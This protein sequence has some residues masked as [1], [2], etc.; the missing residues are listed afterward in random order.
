MPVINN[1]ETDKVYEIQDARVDSLTNIV[2]KCIIIGDSYADGYSPDGSNTSWSTQL[3]NALSNKYNEIITTSLGGVGFIMNISLQKSFKTLLEEVDIDD[4]E[5]VT[6]IIVCGGWNDTGYTVDVL[7]EA[8]NTFMTYAKA[9]YPNALITVGMIGADMN[10]NVKILSLIDIVLKCYSNVGKYGN[11]RFIEN[12]ETILHSR[13]QL[14][15]DRYH[16]NQQGQNDLF[17]KILNFLKGGGVNN[18]WGYVPKYAVSNS[19]PSPYDCVG[20]IN[21]FSC[22][23]ATGFELFAFVFNTPVTIPQGQPFVI[24]D[25]EQ[26]NFIKAGYGEMTNKSVVVLIAYGDG[27]YK[28]E[29]VQVCVNDKYIAVINQSLNDEGTNFKA[30]ENVKTIDFLGAAFYYPQQYI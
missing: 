21:E 25:L 3:K 7:D 26:T 27:T 18:N 5:N 17:S 23:G 8:I 16:P 2:K 14:S 6:D 28:Y 30:L 10:N 15:S 4:K 24:C 11:A 9:T 22:K 13:Q 1:I 20:Y 29:N 19:Q 12:S